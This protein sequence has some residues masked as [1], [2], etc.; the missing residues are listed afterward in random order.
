[1][2]AKTHADPSR[3]RAGATHR[4]REIGGILLLAGGLFA[5]LS[6]LSMHVGGDPMM[7]PGGEAIASGFYGLAGCG[8]YLFSR[9]CWSRPCAASAA[10]AGRRRPRGRRHGCCCSPRSR[11]LLYLPFADSELSRRTARAGCWASGWASIAAGFIGSVGRRAG[12]DDDDGRRAAAGHRDQHARGRGRAGVGGAPRGARHRRRRARVLA[13]DARRLPREGRHATSGA[14]PR[15]RRGTS[16]R[17]R[18]TRTIQIT[19]QAEAHDD[20]RR[21]PVGRPRGRGDG[22]GS[23]ARRA[24]GER[25]RARRRGAHR[26]R[27]S[28]DPERAAMAAI[29]AE[30]AAVER[31]APRAE[32]ALPTRPRPTRLPAIGVP[33]P[34]PPPPRTRRSSSSPRPSRASASRRRPTPPRRPSSA[35]RTPRAARREAGLHQAGR[36]RVPA[37]GHRPA[38]VPPARRRTTPTSSRSTTWPSGWSR[39]CRTTACA[40]R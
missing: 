12:R 17:R 3:P 28:V 24:R 9:A 37:A 16:S 11:S 6:L 7:G 20:R 10:G 25:R 15:A 38:G 13:R 5:G 27:D 31:S 34:P 14:P 26:R 21:E 39:R 19:P 32:A 36:R 30:V 8:V 33:P 22:R 40:A 2:A 35:P 29:V 23:G 1:M 18:R 4:R